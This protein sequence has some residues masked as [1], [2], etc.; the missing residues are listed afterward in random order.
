MTFFGSRFIQLLGAVIVGLVVCAAVFGFGYNLLPPHHTKLWELILI[1]VVGIILGALVG[2]VAWNFI[3]NWVVSIMAAAACTVLILMLLGVA[4]VNNGYAKVGAI[5]VGI[6]VGGYIGKKLNKPIKT[7]G[8]AFIGAF[9]VVRG[10]SF[11]VGGWP[12]EDEEPGVKA[13]NAMFA[14]LGGFIVLFIVG[15][16]VQL[17]MIRDEDIDDDDDDAFKGEDEGRKCGC[18]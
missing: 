8:T 3:K 4:D 2:K 6:F 5:V 17:R 15:A 7:F 13:H 9:L 11:F 12:G 14:Y 10:V 1:L 18:F 16:L